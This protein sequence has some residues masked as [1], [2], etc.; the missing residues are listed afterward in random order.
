MAN[1]ISYSPIQRVGAFLELASLIV[2]RRIVSFEGGPGV[3]IRGFGDLPR[4]GITAAREVEQ[5]ARCCPERNALID[6]CGVL[7][8]QQ[9]RDASRKMAQWLLK[10][11]RE[12]GLKE[13]RIGIM[14]RNGRH[15]VIPFAA[16]SYAGGAGFLLNIG[17]SPEQLVGCIEENDINVLFIDTEFTDRIPADH[18]AMDKVAVVWGHGGTG[19]ASVDKLLV[20][21]ADL[22]K[23]PLIPTQGD[24]VL[25][26]SGTTG[27]PKG[28]LRTEPKIPYVLTGLLSAVPWYAN[29]TVLQ[30]AS[31]F[32]TWGWATLLVGL[33]SRSTIV[34]QREFDPA[35]AMQQIQDFRVDGL[36][37]S[38][39]FYK[40][41]LDLPDNEQWDTSTL[42]W[43]ASSGNSLTPDVVARVHERFGPILANIYGST[44]LSLAAVATA[45]DVAQHPTAAGHVVPGS[46]I[47][48]YDDD[49]N[50]VP[51]GQTGR[52]FLNN[53]TALKGYSN[54]E[55]PLVMIDG[56]IEMGDRGYFDE[57]GRLHVLGR[58]D[59]MIIIGGEN[60][61][62][63]SVTETLEPMPGI[64]DIYSGG[65]D[66]EDTFKRV[67]VW[68]VRSDDETGRNLTADAIR[69]WVRDKLAHHS[70]P[71]DVNFVDSL[72]RNP[73]GKVVPRFLPESRRDD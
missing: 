6:D 23:L 54:P 27:V 46:T 56:L 5:G 60:V 13:L 66:D 10:H 25:M 58:N 2:R 72:P 67:A 4:W 48:L 11:K 68:V 12:A 62:P 59:D 44:E 43:I 47:K 39:I 24:I 14:A 7:T 15:F 17:S 22:P 31:M 3:F 28:I 57:K 55:T 40:Q 38:P 63:Q 37:S 16:K 29:Q 52:I 26:S 36:I 30:S 61:H 18:P 20:S 45:D 53:E 21:D 19:E 1:Q 41:M 42:K 69:D 8:Y 71:R 9:L 33:G 70:I 32:H 35:T 64:A 50:E 49:G 65:V 51:Q 73:T 34:T